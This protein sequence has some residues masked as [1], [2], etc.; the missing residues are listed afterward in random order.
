M[1]EIQNLRYA[2]RVVQHVLCDD[3]LA[4]YFTSH[5]IIDN[6]VCQVGKGTHFAL[7]RF[8]N[9]KKPLH[10]FYNPPSHYEWENI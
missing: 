5:A 9:A 2:D 6:C 4:P 1:R 7:D 3:V 10:A 8:Q